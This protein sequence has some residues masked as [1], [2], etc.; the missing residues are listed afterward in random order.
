MKIA[1]R[2]LMLSLV[3]TLLMHVCI[4]KLNKIDVLVDSCFNR[5]TEAVVTAVAAVAAT[6]EVA[7]VMV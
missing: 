1:G 2:E 5:R 3:V 7:I 4:K 6:V